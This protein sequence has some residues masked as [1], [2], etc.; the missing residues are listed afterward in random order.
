MVRLLMIACAS[1][2]QS[3]TVSDHLHDHF[4]NVLSLSFVVFWPHGTVKAVRI[5]CL[6]L[7]S[8]TVGAPTV[9]A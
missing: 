9:A 4:G 1:A 5:C 3:G 2:V 7:I 6:Y 8:P